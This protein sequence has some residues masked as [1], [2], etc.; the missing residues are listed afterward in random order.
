M[1]KFSK[2]S[3]RLLHPGRVSIWALLMVVCWSL[4][5]QQR[6]SPGVPETHPHFGTWGFETDGMDLAVKPGDD[7]FMYANG[8]WIEKASIPPNRTKVGPFSD[9][10]QLCAEQVHSLVEKTNNDPDDS[11]EG[12]ALTLYQ[13]F[14]DESAI[15]QQ[16]ARP[17]QRDLQEVRRVTRKTE[18]ARLMGR[19]GFDASLFNLEIEK[20]Q[21]HSDRYAVYLG[22]GGLG[23]PDRDFYLEENFADKRSLYEAYVA[24]ILG[25]AEW[26]DAAESASAVVAFETQI[27]KVSWRGEDVRDEAKTYH[28]MSLA[29]LQRMAPTFPW[30]VFMAGAHLSGSRSLIVTTDTSVVKLAELFRK[31]PLSTL[32]AWEAF[33]SADAAA[34]YLPKAFAEARFQFRDHALN[35]LESP[36]ERWVSAVSLLNDQMGS[37]VGKMYVAA[38]FPPERKAAVEV[39]A[40]NIKQALR[41]D[42]MQLTWM[43]SSTRAE[44]LRKLDRIAVQMG[45][46]EHWRSYA[47]VN[48]KNKTLYE[49]VDT[50]QEHNWQYH[51][52]ELT[53]TWNKNDWRFWPQQPSAYTENGQLVFPAGMLQA[54]FFDVQADAAVNYG[55]IGQ[56]IGHELTHPFDDQGRMEDSRFQTRDWWTPEDNQRYKEQADRLAKQYS[57]MEPLPGVH[58]K[59]D[60]T[61]GENIADLGGLVLAYKAYRSMLSHDTD[62]PERGFTHDQEFFLGYAQVWREKVRSDAL[63]NGLASDVHSPASARLNGVVQNMPQWYEAFHVVAGDR[64]YIAPDERVAIW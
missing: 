48:L 31:T 57:A 54:P 4:P 26:P 44:A 1:L 28:P 12:R 52:S 27:A 47:G 3:E 16:G 18:V 43:E 59:G 36:P 60:L 33:R 5:A 11:D 2:L 50:L 17:L 49:D 32:K 23:L 42:L 21:K 55:S 38:Y 30:R 13:A 63:R 10:R 41:S 19:H 46:P 64:M 25:L 37:T 62:V 40:E 51:V 29:D 9:L 20:D 34:P 35:G 24:K 58:I 56:V 14:M 53:K 8:A 61:I 7:F 39:I 22:Q 15:E 6:S 45:Y